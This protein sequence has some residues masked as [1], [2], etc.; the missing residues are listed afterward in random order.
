M[1][2]VKVLLTVMLLV[3]L[4]LAGYVVGPLVISNADGKASINAGTTPESRQL[5]RIARPLERMVS[6]LEGPPR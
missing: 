5:D 1:K 6:A 3:N 4:A 2:T